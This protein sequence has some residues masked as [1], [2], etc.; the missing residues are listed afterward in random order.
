MTNFDTRITNLRH[1]IEINLLAMKNKK[2][3]DV[4]FCKLSDDNAEL[5]KELTSI[6]MKRNEELDMKLEEFISRRNVK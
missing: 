3:S 6:Y 2:L 1:E 5:M 4:M